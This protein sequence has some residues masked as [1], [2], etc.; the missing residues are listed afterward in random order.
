ME[1]IITSMPMLV[2]AVLTAQLC[3]SLVSRWDRPRFRLLLFM[4]AA[5][6]LYTAHYIFFNRQTSA[7]PLSDTIYSFCN[8]AVFP[9]YLIYIEELTLNRPSRWRQAAYIT[10]AVLCFL[11]VGSLYLLMSPD[12]TRVFIQHHL[13]GDEYLSLSGLARWQAEA[14][15]LVKIVFAAQIPP[16][17]ILG[18]RRIT[19]YNQFIKGNYSNTEGKMLTPVRS[20][21]I[22]LVAASLLSFACNVIGRFRFADTI[23]LL[24]IPSAVFSLLILLIGHI[25]LNQNFSIANTEEDT[26]PHPLETDD[27]QAAPKTDAQSELKDRVIRLVEQERLYLQPNLKISDLAERLNT[28]R[29]Y[30]YNA[31][32]VELGISFSELIN[33]KRIE[34]AAAQIR[35]DPKKLLADIAIISGFTSTSAF[36]RNFKQF[37]HCTP[38]QYQREMLDAKPSQ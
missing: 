36:Y 32:N 29:N 19:E 18:W 11:T 31:V 21:L 3:L 8:P 6:L 10:P 34:F 23:W 15:L 2:C 17:L 26:S 20:L 5:T 12:E 14:H 13:Y 27:Q 28:N 37:K 4:A 33:Q 30:I 22:L 35:R 25:G 38:S 24:A 1:S 9:L 16:V 7:I